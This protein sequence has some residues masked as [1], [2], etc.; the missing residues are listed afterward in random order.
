MSELGV[1]SIGPYATV[2]LIAIMTVVVGTLILAA[3]QP[4]T[5]R[6]VAVT[7]E[8]HNSTGTVP[9]TVTLTHCNNGLY[10]NAVIDKKDNDTNTVTR[11]GLTTAGANYTVLSTATCMFNMTAAT[12][13]N[14]TADTY[15]FNYTY[16]TDTN[17]TSVIR[18]GV[19]AMSSFA[20]WFGILVIVF[21]AVIVISLV[22]MLGRQRGRS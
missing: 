15:W 20:D 5:Y 6:N 3:M 19:L 21:I 22:M 9:E 17:A 4:M 16:K 14:E 13:I 10:G 2:I 1:K 12:Y 8:Y 7:N 11:M 18:K